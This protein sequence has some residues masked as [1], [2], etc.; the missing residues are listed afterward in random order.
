M[1]KNWWWWMLRYNGTPP[2]LL[3]KKAL[4]QK[5][6]VRRKRWRRCEWSWIFHPSLT[7]FGSPC[8]FSLSFLCL[9]EQ[10][11]HKGPVG[12]IIRNKKEMCR[13][14]PTFRTCCHPPPRNKKKPLAIK[15]NEKRKFPMNRKTKKNGYSSTNQFPLDEQLKE[16]KILRF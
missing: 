8:V 2:S 6:Q 12:C 10:L 11:E 7:D 3:Q 4:L 14:P 13:V 5:E 1:V 9:L 16:K 15:V